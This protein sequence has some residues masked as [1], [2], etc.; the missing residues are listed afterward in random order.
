MS[1][2]CWHSTDH[3]HTTS[4]SDHVDTMRNP[5]LCPSARACQVLSGMSG[6]SVSV[7]AVPLYMVDDCCLVSDSTLRSLRSAD[8]PTYVVPRTLSSY[9]DRTFAATG[10]HL[11]N[12]L[13]VQL[14]NTHITYGLFRWQLTKSFSGSMNAA[15]CDFWHAA[16]YHHHHH[17]QRNICS[18]PITK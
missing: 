18:A 7:W 6:L 5:F 14:H 3:C 4:W 17:L 13:P 16:A 10:P 9:G 8:V 11:W 2:T 12:C 15:L 1:D